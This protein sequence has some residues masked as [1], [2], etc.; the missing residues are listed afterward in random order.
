MG[1]RGIGSR[2]KIEAVEKYKR[3][4]GSQKSLAREYGVR[5]ASF[6]QWIANYDSMGPSGLAVRHTNNEYSVDQKTAVVEAYLRGEE[7]RLKYAGGIVSAVRRSSG[8]G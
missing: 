1:R 3:G 8:N 7:A 5:K 4:E 6:Q 2:E